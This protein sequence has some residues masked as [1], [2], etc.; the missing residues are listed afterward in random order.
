ME[1]NKEGTLVLPVTRVAIIDDDTFMADL[2]S[3][4]FV[5]I[6]FHPTVCHNMEDAL[7]IMDST[8]FALVVSDIFMP[9]MGGIEGIRIIRDRFPK[10]K[11]IAVSGGWEN[12]SATDALSAAKS[13]GADTALGKPVAPE[14]LKATLDGLGLAP[15]LPGFG[16]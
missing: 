8:E 11:I 1:P 9:G 15:L 5:R 6:G 12:M 14:T 4:I 10:V 2:L 3:L 13:V 7:A 16:H